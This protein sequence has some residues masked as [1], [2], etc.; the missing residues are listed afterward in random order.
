MERV[1]ELFLE[2]ARSLD[3]DL[4]FQDFDDELAALPGEY[5]PP[6]GCILLALEDGGLAGSVALRPLSAGVCEMKRLYVRPEYRGRAVGRRL[7]ETIIREARTRGYETMRLDTV[8]TMKQAIGLYRALG[9]REI[10][11]YRP[12]PVP[13]ALFFE[14]H[15][16][17]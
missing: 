8:P 1:R 11:A 10:A 12:N 15:L 5:A 7:A 16:E 9:F 13:G 14:L 6:G 4:C 3:F 17:S 2:Y